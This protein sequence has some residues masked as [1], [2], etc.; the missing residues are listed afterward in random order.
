MILI[1]FIRHG[2][3]QANEAG[4]W[5]GR[6]DD[7]ITQQAVLELKRLSA[8]YPYP[9]ADMIYRSPLI[10]CRQTMEALYPGKDAVVLNELVE[11]D[12]GNFEGAYA[13]NAVKKLG[14]KPIREK[15]LDFAFPNGES[16]RDCFNRAVTA[17]DQIVSSAQ[18]M[19]HH[20]VAVM[21]H[22]MWIATFLQH[23][24]SPG[25]RTEQ[26]FCPNGMGISVEIDP[27]EWF[28]D[29]VAHFIHY[30]PQGAPRKRMED[31]PYHRI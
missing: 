5:I 29:R 13:P 31:S 1:D 27:A 14:E 16:F 18:N 28:H 11:I 23:C 8:A 25:M 7:P 30:I 17:M 21:A 12:F 9:K 19:G 4:R 3:T 24:L 20:S 10:R 22:A 6:T 2:T 26:L 15:E